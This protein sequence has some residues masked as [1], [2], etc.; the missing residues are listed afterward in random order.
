[1]CKTKRKTNGMATL[2]CALIVAPVLLM[3]PTWANAQWTTADGSGNINNTNTNNVGV[4]TTTPGYKLDITTLVDKAQIRFGLGAID[5][6]GYL[7]SNGPNHAALSGGVSVGAS[8]W[9]ARSMSASIIEA[10]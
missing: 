7:Y 3:W 1:M 4:G 10:N 5:S 2:V 8:G 6:G 9:T